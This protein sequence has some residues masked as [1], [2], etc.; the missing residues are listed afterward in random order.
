MISA[1]E[2]LMSVVVLVV[3]TV[4]FEIFW[5]LAVVLLLC[6]PATYAGIVA[7]F[8]INRVT[9]NAML[10]FGAAVLAYALVRLLIA[11]AVRGFFTRCARRRRAQ[12][13]PTW[14]EDVASA[15]AQRRGKEIS[16]AWPQGSLRDR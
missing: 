12:S 8:G 2:I 7:G 9:H 4:L 6:G 10:S 3:V 14:S 16:R 11:W 5:G 1:P 15:R 13:W